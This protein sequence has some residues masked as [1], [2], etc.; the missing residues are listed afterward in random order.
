M[1]R[2]LLAP[3]KAGYQGFGLVV[4]GLAHLHPPLGQVGGLVRIAH[5]GHDVVGGHPAL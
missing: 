3:V 5:G 2:S 1:S 4:V